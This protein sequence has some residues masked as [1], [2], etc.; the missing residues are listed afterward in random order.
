M[1][2]TAKTGIV[3]EV[4]SEERGCSNEITLSSI[5][6]R[7]AVKTL[8]NLANRLLLVS[9]TSYQHFDSVNIINSAWERKIMKEI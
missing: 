7:L 3:F 6:R 4:P 8:F 5:I 2:V 1:V 9:V